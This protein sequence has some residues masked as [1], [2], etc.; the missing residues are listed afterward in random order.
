MTT[1]FKYIL[2]SGAGYIFKYNEEGLPLMTSDIDEALRHDFQSAL[3][4]LEFLNC[5]DF[6]FFIEIVDVVYKKPNK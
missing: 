4:K 5:S 2:K 1:N 6:Y 3:D